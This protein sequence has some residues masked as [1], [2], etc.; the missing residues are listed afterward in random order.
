M[1]VQQKHCLFDS[2]LDKSNFNHLPR[3]IDRL[4]KNEKR[5]CHTC[6][7]MVSFPLEMFLWKGDTPWQLAFS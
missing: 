3:P 5:S 1:Q 2:I 6:A 4:Y 7:R